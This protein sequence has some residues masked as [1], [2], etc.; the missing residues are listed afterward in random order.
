MLKL[1]VDSNCGIDTINKMGHKKRTVLII[2]DTPSDFTDIKII[3]KEDL[4]NTIIDIVTAIKNKNTQKV[5][6]LD[7]TQKFLNRKKK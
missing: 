6:L 5:I 3:S 4:R 1:E 7:D 2:Q